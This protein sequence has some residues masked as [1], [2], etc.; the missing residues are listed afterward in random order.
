MRAVLQ[1]LQPHAAILEGKDK[2]RQRVVPARTNGTR[3]R[4]TFARP[5]ASDA[6]FGRKLRIRRRGV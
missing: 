5:V 4:L 6:V 3:S 1:L 2:M